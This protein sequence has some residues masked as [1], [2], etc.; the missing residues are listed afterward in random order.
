M[1]NYFT[2]Q[3]SSKLTYLYPFDDKPVLTSKSAVFFINY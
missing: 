3:Q 2:C 1:I